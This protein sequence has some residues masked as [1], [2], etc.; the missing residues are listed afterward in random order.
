MLVVD[1]NHDSILS[2]HNLLLEVIERTAI[3]FKGFEQ[4]FS[5]CS[6]TLF[7]LLI[8]L[9]LIECLDRLQPFLARIHDSRV[10]LI[11]C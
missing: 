5:S 9:I 7:L 2:F 1:C 10:P 3:L 11:V 4:V 6:V 8:F